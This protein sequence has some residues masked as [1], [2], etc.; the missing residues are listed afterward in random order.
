MIKLLGVFLLSISLS[1]PVIAKEQEILGFHGTWTAYKH[2]DHGNN[3]C[4]IASPPTKSSAD[5]KNRD[6]N[7][8]LITHRPGDKTRNVVSHV[9]GFRYN[10]KKPVVADVDG[11]KFM[12]IASKDTAWT[13]NQ[14]TDDILTKALKKG[15]TLK[16]IGTGR[17]GTVVTDTYSL[18]G[19]TASM[20]LID[21]A[22]KI[23]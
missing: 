13:P 18:K 8:L 10:E 11:K 16:V 20:R 4:Y 5:I 6:P 14:D 7:F 23:K 9:A 22:C 2:K 17:R 21:K 15:R 19:V 12:M 3:V 1:F